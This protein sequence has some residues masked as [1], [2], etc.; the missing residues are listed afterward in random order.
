LDYSG[1]AAV[2]C[3]KQLEEDLAAL[4]PCT[5]SDVVANAMYAIQFAR[6]EIELLR[7]ALEGVIAISD[8][9]IAVRILA[10]GALKHD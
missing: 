4:I 9:P 7:A 6:M 5:R 2:N 8:N 3:T 10:S 1:V